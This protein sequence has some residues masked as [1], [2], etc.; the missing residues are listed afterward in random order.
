MAAEGIYGVGYVVEFDGWR[1]K[2]YC[3]GGG[4]NT[5]DLTMAKVYRSRAAAMR[6]WRDVARYP[7]VKSGALLEVKVV[8]EGR[9]GLEM[10]KREDG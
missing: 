4:N 2:M 8:E 5:T 1:G 10:P 9:V 3:R 6:A 7:F